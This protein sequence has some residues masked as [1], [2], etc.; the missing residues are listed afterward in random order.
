MTPTAKF[1]KGD[2]V[3]I[4][5]T[6]MYRGH[7]LEMIIPDGLLGIIVCDTWNSGNFYIIHTG[8]RSLSWNVKALT[9]I[10]KSEFK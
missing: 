1:E 5:S 8:D 9:L 10:S 7:I 2:L 6:V 4:D 3:Y